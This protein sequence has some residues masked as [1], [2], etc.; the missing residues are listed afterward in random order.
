MGLDLGQ[1]GRRAFGVVG[2]PA[3]AVKQLVEGAEHGLAVEQRLAGSPDEAAMRPL[4]ERLPAALR[5]PVA[6][7]GGT[8]AQP[9]FEADVLGLGRA[10]CRT[11]AAPEPGELEV[12][13]DRRRPGAPV[14]TWVTARTSSRPSHGLVRRAGAVSDSSAR[15]RVDHIRDAR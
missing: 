4:H 8:V 2:A 1:L 9:L 3:R 10:G 5:L 11:S 14:T 12:V 6:T 7:R 13:G 15:D